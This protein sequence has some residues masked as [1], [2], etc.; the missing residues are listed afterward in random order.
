VRAFVA[1]GANLNDP[2]AQVRAGAAALDRLPDTRR[3]SCSS[4]YRTAPIGRTDQPEFINAVCEIETALPARDLMQALLVIEREHGR[5]RDVA[6]GPRTLDLDLLLYGDRV[7]DE[8]G[9]T[10][11]HP[12]LHERAFVLYPLQ[13]IAPGLAIPGRGRVDDLAAGC[14]GQGIERLAQ[15]AG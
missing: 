11:P 3:I 14:A 1:L 15:R 13:E 2:V 8:P 6:G 5:V 4:L 7:V 10:V 9:L 12:R